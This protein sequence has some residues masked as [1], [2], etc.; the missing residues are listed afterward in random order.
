MALKGRVV[1]LGNANLNPAVVQR[2]KDL[3]AEKVTLMVRES[4]EVNTDAFPADVLTGHAVTRILG[5][6]RRL[7]GMEVVTSAGESQT[8]EADHLIFSAGR[9][10]EMIYAPV[11]PPAESGDETNGSPI[12]GQ[13]QAMPPYK[14]PSCQSEIGFLAGG[15]P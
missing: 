9:F 12:P 4:S 2:C 15:M 1:I 10:P 7:T 6:D 14:K 8:I 11:M 3:G 13:W 5:S